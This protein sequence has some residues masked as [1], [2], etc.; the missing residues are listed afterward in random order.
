MDAQLFTASSLD[1]VVT[2]VTPTFT[3]NRV[4]E[5]IEGEPTRKQ[6]KAALRP[7]PG[8][9]RFANAELAAAAPMHFFFRW[10]RDLVGVRSRI[11]SDDG[12][13]YEVVAPPEEIGR[14]KWLRVLG[15]ARAE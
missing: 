9:E 10:E 14:R 15:S 8:T 5:E 2:I 7:A 13:T 12:R 11:E 1:R 6:R 4:N 3:K